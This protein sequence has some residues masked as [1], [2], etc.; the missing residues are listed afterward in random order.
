[1]GKITRYSVDIL[2][3]EEGKKSLD[4]VGNDKYTFKDLLEDILKDHCPAYVEV[5]IIEEK[6]GYLVFQEDKTK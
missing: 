4:S 5:T 1:M 3:D 6:T 2:V